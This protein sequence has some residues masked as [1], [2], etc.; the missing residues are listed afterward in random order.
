MNAKEKVALAV[1]VIGFASLVG[2]LAL[3][4]IPTAAIV[5]GALLIAFGAALDRHA[6]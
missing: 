1:M 4:H 6:V 2:G 3:V 5:A